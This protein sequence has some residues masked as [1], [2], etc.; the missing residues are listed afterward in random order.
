MRATRGQTHLRDFILRRDSSAFRFEIGAL[1]PRSFSANCAK[2]NS[3]QWLIDNSEHRLSA[4][5]ET[6]LHSEVSVAINETGCPVEGIDH[7]NAFLIK[8]ARGVDGFFGED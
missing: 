1:D 6:N 7:P 4:F 2:E 5:G 8:T 3:A